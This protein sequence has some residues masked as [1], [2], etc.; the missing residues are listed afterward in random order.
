MKCERC[1]Y[2]EYAMCI[3]VHHID[4]NHSN[5][6]PSNLIQLCAICH[7]LLHNNM[8]KLEDL[9]AKF[10]TYTIMTTYF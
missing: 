8:W 7:R 5:N 3:D 9:D 1:G 10:K 4:E 6:D 2:N